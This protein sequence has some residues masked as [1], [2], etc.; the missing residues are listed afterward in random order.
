[1]AKPTLKKRSGNSSWRALA[2]PM[3][4]TFQCLAR[5]PR[6]SVSGPGTSIARLA[7]VRRVV[8]VEHLVGEAL[9]RA[10]GQQHQAHRQVEAGE[11][12]RRRDQV[13]EVVEV[14]LDLGPLADAA[15][16][17]ESGQ[18]PST[19]WARVRLRFA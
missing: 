18:R 15:D 4:N 7:R 13:A 1:M 9:Q 2:W 14:A 16:R 19:A 10:L 17:A 12:R 8:Q 11:P 6:K 5:S 3:M